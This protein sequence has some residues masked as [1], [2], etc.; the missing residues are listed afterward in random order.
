[1]PRGPERRLQAGYGIVNSCDVAQLNGEKPQAHARA[2]KDCPVGDP[3]IKIPIPT[4]GI[5]GRKGMLRGDSE[6]TVMMS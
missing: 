4:E 2:S 3:G 5:S 1:M 6:R